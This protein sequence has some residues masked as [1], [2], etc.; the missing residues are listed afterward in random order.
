MINTT[1]AVYKK[2]VYLTLFI[3]FGLYFAMLTNL[4]FTKL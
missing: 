2:A 1:A 3:L 4:N